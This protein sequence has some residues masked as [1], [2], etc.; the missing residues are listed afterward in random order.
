MMLPPV[1]ARC[2]R[3]AIAVRIAAFRLTVHDIFEH[4][5][6]ELVIRPRNAGGIDQDIE[7]IEAADQPLRRVAIP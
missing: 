2:A 7:T 5:G 4:L 6:L 3:A 1:A